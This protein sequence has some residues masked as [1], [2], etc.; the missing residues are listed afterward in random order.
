MLY[1]NLYL[2]G[3]NVDAFFNR[4]AAL[5]FEKAVI[6]EAE[7][8]TTDAGAADGNDQIISRPVW[9]IARGVCLISTLLSA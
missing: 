5:A 2:A 4:V 1:D 3:E 7:V 6:R 8:D 9:F